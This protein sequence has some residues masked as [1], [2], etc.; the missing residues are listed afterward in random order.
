MIIDRW[1]AIQARQAAVADLFHPASPFTC[2]FKLAFCF[3]KGPL[4]FFF[5]TCLQ[6]PGWPLR[7]KLYSPVSSVTSIHGEMVVS[8]N[9][10]LCRGRF[11]PS[12]HHIPA[13]ASTCRLC[14]GVGNESRS[15][16]T[17]TLLPCTNDGD[18][19]MR[20]TTAFIPDMKRARDRCTRGELY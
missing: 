12:I 4:I 18:M 8:T 6:F 13:R 16:P 3:P 1:P 2:Q 17:W 14:N 11:S 19:A 9:V 15:V 20:S 5:I 10:S 7:S